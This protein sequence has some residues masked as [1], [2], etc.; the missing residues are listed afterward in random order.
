[1]YYE[2]IKKFLFRLSPETAHHFV[3]KSLKLAY[4]LGLST[5]Y[6]TLPDSPVTVCGLTFK[7]PIGLAAGLDKNGEYIDALAAL[8]FGFIEVGTVTRL[9]QVGNPP[10]RLFRL[11]EQQAI[12]NRMGFNNKG[13]DY[14]VE[15]LKNIRYRGIL[16]IN[17]GKNRDTANEQAVAEYVYCFRRVYSYASY[18]T[19]NISSPNT[20][21]LRDLQQGEMLSA[22]LSALKQEQQVLSELQK[23]Y[24]PLFVK[25]APDL[26]ETEL[27]HLAD[28]M[29]A[30]K[31][32]GIIATNTTIHRDG[33]EA[34]P[35]ANEAGGLS[36]K[37]LLARSTAVVRQLHE[38]LQGKV[39][40]I[41]VGGILTSEDAKTKWAAGASLIQLYSGLVFTGPAL[42]YSTVTDFA[43]LRG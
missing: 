31:I 32:D 6:P 1:M 5:L 12:I 40:I 7:N 4:T 35:C 14:L 27:Q 10:P 8:G 18:I 16:G 36:G 15:Q 38:L 23:K 17:I 34:S 29:L 11:P 24:V 30:E 21:G 22:L 19:I 33:V 2:F 42:V 25:I 39:P 20:K 43:K 41:A 28:V 37:P 9:P 26:S 13:V 3:L